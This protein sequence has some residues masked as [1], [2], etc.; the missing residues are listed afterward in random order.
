MKKNQCLVELKK[1]LKKLEKERDK[2]LQRFYNSK[3]LYQQHTKDWKE[4]KKLE[5]QIKKLKGMI[6]IKEEIE[7][8]K[9]SKIYDMFGKE[10]NEGDIV[11][12]VHVPH[13]KTE[14]ALCFYT[15]VKHKHSSRLS[16]ELTDISK[17]ILGTDLDRFSLVK[18][19]KK[20]NKIIK[21]TE[22][23]YPGLF[24][25]FNKRKLNNIVEKF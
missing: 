10:V 14:T 2:I 19:N 15:A 24:A 16:F 12:T 25:E 23:T 9:N 18:T 11:I 7:K 5:T 8:Y 6:K 22:E 13:Y 3:T 1:E 21:I 20:S 17:I 4:E